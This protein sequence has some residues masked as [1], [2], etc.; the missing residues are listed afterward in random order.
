MMMLCVSRWLRCV[1]RV[2]RLDTLYGVGCSLASFPGWPVLMCGTAYNVFHVA[3]VI[4][5]LLV[6]LVGMTGLGL[7]FL[8][9]FFRDQT[10]YVIATLAYVGDVC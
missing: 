3:W 6:W 7:Y 8:L 9:K 10:L 1:M 2:T 5:L 4:V